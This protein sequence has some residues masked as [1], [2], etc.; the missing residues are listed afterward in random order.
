M[1]KKLYFFLLSFFFFSL[2]AQDFHYSQF[3]NSPITT[4]PALTGMT[5]GVFR[6]GGIYRNQ[7]WNTTQ[8]FLNT[9]YSTPSISIDAP[10][11]IKKS[12]IGLGLVLMNDR[13]SG[14]LLNDYV[15][16][17]SFSYILGV[18]KDQNHL[19]SFGVQGSY[20]NRSFSDDLQ[21]ASQFE[22]NEFNSNFGSPEALKGETFHHGDLNAGIA[23]QAKF[24]ERVK[25]NVGFSAFNLIAMDYSSL[26]GSSKDNYRR[27][28]GQI[29]SDISF[30]EKIAILPSVL[31]MQ[32]N[33]VNQMNAGM[34][35]AYRFTE[36]TR[37]YLGV[38]ARSTGWVSDLNM[39]AVIPYAGIDI[40]RFKIGMSY[41]YTVSGLKN[42]PQ[43]TGAME[44]SLI[45]THKKN[46][47]ET[48]P[49]N[50]FCPRF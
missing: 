42:A 4:N 3:Y 27:F 1:A 8:S 11:Y 29:G 44:L 7:W 5:D 21:F 28:S 10:I 24:T 34:A 33:N 18:G 31:F 30:T 38:Y 50:L 17:G 13:V 26:S 9:A 32:Q 2:N 48:P 37:L 6:V 45:Y 46:S 19:I 22:D 49:L 12:A 25:F 35:F 41:D 47:L 40:K 20:T 15:A 39:D 14:G 23:Y 16:L 36:S 43:N